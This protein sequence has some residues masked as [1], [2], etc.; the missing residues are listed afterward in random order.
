MFSL[1][2][3]FHNVLNCNVSINHSVHILLPLSCRNDCNPHPTITKPNTIYL[4][5][6]SSVIRG[7]RLSRRPVP[8][9][10]PLPCIPSPCSRSTTPCP[11]FSS[12]SF[13]AKRSSQETWK[14]REDEEQDESTL[15]HGSEKDRG[16]AERRR[17]GKVRLNLCFIRT[18]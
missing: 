4:T 17:R 9:H 12:S 7:V 8:F 2:F 15:K 16:K 11:F 5:H 18:R 1:L 6:H 10:F 14:K 13:L 3:S